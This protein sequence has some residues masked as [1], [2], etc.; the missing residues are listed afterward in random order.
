[1]RPNL[2]AAVQHAASDGPSP[3]AWLPAYVL[4]NHFCASRHMVDWLAT[5]NAALCAA[6]AE[7][8]LLAQA[9]AQRCLGLP[10]TSWAGDYTRASEHHTSALA[11]IA[12]PPGLVR[13]RFWPWDIHKVV[14]W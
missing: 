7:G 11:R 2:V 14:L 8:D 1:V 12:L 3:V 5:A 10:A 6:Q 9:A 4:R 13:A